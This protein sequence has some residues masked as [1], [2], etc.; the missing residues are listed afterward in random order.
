MADTDPVALPWDDDALMI[1]DT[2]APEPV[3]SQLK[4]EIEQLAQR[5]GEDRV[6]VDTLLHI[7]ELL[8]GL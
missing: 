5:R 2:H 6:T 7:E 4:R 1:L 8:H 3:R